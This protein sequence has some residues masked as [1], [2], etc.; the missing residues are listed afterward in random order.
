MIR[1]HSRLFSLSIFVLT[2]LAPLRGEAQLGRAFEMG[3]RI[4]GNS[5]HPA[6]VFLKSRSN[7]LVD[8][9]IRSVGRL[10]NEYESFG[11]LHV[12]VDSAGRSHEPFERLINYLERCP[13]EACFRVLELLATPS[14]FG[15]NGATLTLDAQSEFDDLVAY[16]L[17]KRDYEYQARYERYLDALDRSDSPQSFDEFWGNGNDITSRH[18]S[19]LSQNGLD[20]SRIA[21]NPYLPEHLDDVARNR[22]LGLWTLARRNPPRPH[23]IRGANE[24]LYSWIPFSETA[25]V[26]G[27]RIQMSRRLT[28]AVVHMLDI[29]RASYVKWLRQRTRQSHHQIIKGIYGTVSAA[30]DYLDGIFI[31]R[32]A[33]RQFAS[34]EVTVSVLDR[35]IMRWMSQS[36]ISAN[37]CNEFNIKLFEV[38]NDAFTHPHHLS[39]FNRT[40]A[41]R[42]LFVRYSQGKIGLQEFRR[43]RKVHLQEYRGQNP[44]RAFHPRML[45]LEAEI[46]L[47]QE[48]ISQLA[49]LRYRG[50][51][52]TSIIDQ[53]LEIVEGYRRRLTTLEFDREELSRQLEQLGSERARLDITE[54]AKVRIRQE[55]DRVRS[56]LE[57]LEDLE[58]ARKALADAEKELRRYENEFLELNDQLISARNVHR[59]YELPY[60]LSD[61]EMKS[62]ARRYE[63]IFARSTPQ[64]IADDI[65][66]FN[67]QNEVT[68]LKTIRSALSRRSRQHSLLVEAGGIRNR[69]QLKGF[70]GRQISALVKRAD[71]AKKGSL[72]TA[73]LGALYASDYPQELVSWIAEQI[74]E[75]VL[76]NFSILKD[77]AESEMIFPEMQE[78]KQTDVSEQSLPGEDVPFEIPSND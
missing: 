6:R 46:L 51:P 56:A 63:D 55:M 64:I 71:L 41:N 33:V 61:V 22:T 47:I 18:T 26:L 37:R 15:K 75:S 69:D 17:K 57:E 65:H 58:P 39:H 54:E 21:E 72:S 70:L 78:D 68:A 28:D 42:D 30:V 24:G 44:G 36:H 7:S 48:R 74:P 35:E 40:T 73:V 12:Y 52:S 49:G 13:S 20:D 2:L 10:G 76:K 53:Q 27:D 50:V 60:F 16:I 19:G 34:G 62:L 67:R 9:L 23:Q 3:M 66:R 5:D 31:R 32:K 11:H 25:A 45:E 8:E 1:L 4:L 43:L 77:V 59:Y 14:S 38:Y 29:E